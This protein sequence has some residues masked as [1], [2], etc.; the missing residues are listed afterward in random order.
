MFCSFFLQYYKW[1]FI[2][3]F[4]QMFIVGCFCCIPEN[5][6]VNDIKDFLLCISIQ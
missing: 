5:I 2:Y 1:F 3:P 4:E 6:D